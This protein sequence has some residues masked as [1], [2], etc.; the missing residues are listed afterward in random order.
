MKT[1]A[2]IRANP[3]PAV[4]AQSFKPFFFEVPLLATVRIPFEFVH[5][6][7]WI[8]PGRSSI[9]HRSPKSNL[10]VAADILTLASQLHYHSQYCRPGG[11]PNMSRYRHSFEKSS[12]RNTYLKYMHYF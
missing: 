12:Q 5:G 9:L 8:R 3:A 1:L 2:A 11:M 7:E 4:A 10:Q 6:S